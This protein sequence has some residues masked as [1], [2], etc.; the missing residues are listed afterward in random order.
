M[1]ITGYVLAFVIYVVGFYPLIQSTVLAAT[2]LDPL[3]ASLIAIVPAAFFIAMIVGIFN[4]ALGR[5][6]AGA[7]GGQ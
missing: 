6:P 2:D 5:R 1:T 7:W 4:Y 3:S